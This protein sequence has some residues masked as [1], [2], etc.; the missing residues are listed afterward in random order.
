MLLRLLQYDIVV[1]YT[2]GKEMHIADTLSKAYIL[3]EGQACFRTG[4]VLYNEEQI[5]KVIILNEKY[6]RISHHIKVDAPCLYWAKKFD[7]VWTDALWLVMKKQIIGGNW[8]M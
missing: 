8:L 6:K 4:R 3:I 2:K 1:K 7:I 5:A